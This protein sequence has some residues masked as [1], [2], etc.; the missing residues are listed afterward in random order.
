MLQGTLEQGQS[1]HGG[2]QGTGSLE[3]SYS[4]LNTW[5]KNWIDPEGGTWRRNKI[6]CA[7]NELGILWWL[8]VFS[9]P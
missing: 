4:L 5:D 3:V 1:R 8:H 6:K 9:T 7:K 2:R